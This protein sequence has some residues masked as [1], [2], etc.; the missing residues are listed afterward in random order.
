MPFP[1]GQLTYSFKSS[2]KERGNLL[3]ELSLDADWF[4]DPERTLSLLDIF[5]YK[6]D[7]FIWELRTAVRPLEKIP[8]FESKGWETDSESKR[9]VVFKLGRVTMIVEQKQIIF[10]GI[11][12]KEILEIQD[13]EDSDI[14]R[15][16]DTFQML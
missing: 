11:D 2:T 3:R 12:I 6:S 8:A 7:E 15:I 5:D 1:G 16:K 9:R 13:E 14:S 4:D 10:N